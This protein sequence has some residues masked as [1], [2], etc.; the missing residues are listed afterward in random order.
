MN[1]LNAKQLLVR[2]FELGTRLYCNVL[3]NVSEE[4]ASVRIHD[5]SNH[6]KWIAGHLLTIRNRNAIRIGAAVQ[7]FVHADKYAVNG[8]PPPNAR[9][10]DVAIAYPSIGEIRDE[11]SACSGPFVAAVDALSDEQLRTEASFS[12][13]IG[14]KTTLEN[15]AFMAYHEAFHIGQMSI[16]RKSIGLTPMSFR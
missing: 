8:M 3:D 14:G 12:T 9:A 7:P 5:T 6:L 16:I 4:D 11:W 1:I 2:Q 15:L 10:L 13:P